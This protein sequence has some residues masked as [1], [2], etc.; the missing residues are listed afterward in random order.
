MRYKGIRKKIKKVKNK[1]AIYINNKKI[2]KQ[3]RAH[4]KQFRKKCD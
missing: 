2:K 3:K 4:K 1:K